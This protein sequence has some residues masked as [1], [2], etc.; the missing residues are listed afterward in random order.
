MNHIRGFDGLR[1]IA[2]LLVVG[3]HYGHYVPFGWIGVPIFFVISGFLITRILVAAR[4]KAKVGAGVQQG[5]AGAAGATRATRSG[6]QSYFRRFYWR[7]TLRIFPLYY[8]IVFATGGLYLATGKPG[9]FPLDVGYLVTYLYNYVFVL[10]GREG[11][12]FFS[13]FWSLAIEERFYLF[14]PALVWFLSRGS[15][16]AVVVGLIVA[17]PLVRYATALIAMQQGLEGEEVAIAVNRLL[18]SH[19]DAFAWGAA[20]TLFDVE[21]IPR[22][23]ELACAT[24]VLCLAVSVGVLLAT[25]GTFQWHLGLRQRGVA[26]YE[27]VWLPTLLDLGSAA[28]LLAVSSGPRL[29]NLLEWGPLTAIGRISYGYYVYHMPLREVL[30]M[31]GLYRPD[32]VAGLIGFPVYLGLVFAISW[33]SYR[34]LE[35]PLLELKDEFDARA[36]FGANVRRAA[37]VWRARVFSRGFLRAALLPGTRGNAG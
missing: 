31:V 11:G 1:A 21:K 28:T 33:V 4:E 14:W 2:A 9:S 26:N 3:Y 22:R 10:T 25:E 35:E 32:T 36:G 15:F 29:A 12:A 23:F 34:L 37:G 30:K 24:V 5:A 20:L 7:R 27:Y 13:H 6:E 17:G 18:T 8:F 19:L 16:R